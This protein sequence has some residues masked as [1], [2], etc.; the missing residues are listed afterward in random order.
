MAL[1]HCS[2]CWRIVK[3]CGTFDSQMYMYDEIETPCVCLTP[4]RGLISRISVIGVRETESGAHW[5]VYE[6]QGVV[7]APRM[8]LCCKMIN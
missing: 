5:I 2:I 1:D 8:R 6:E 7:H 3:V 4:H